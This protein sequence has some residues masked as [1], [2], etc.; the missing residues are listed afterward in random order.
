[1]RLSL[2]LSSVSAVTR[3]TT[4]GTDENLPPAPPTPQHP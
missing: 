3:H 2:R 4:A 1:M